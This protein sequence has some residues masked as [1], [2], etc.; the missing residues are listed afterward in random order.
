MDFDKG[1]LVFAGL[2]PSMEDIPDDDFDDDMGS[3]SN[4]DGMTGEK[5]LIIKNYLMT[6][7]GAQ[8][9]SSQKIENLTHNFYPTQICEITFSEKEASNGTPA[10]TLFLSFVSGVFSTKNFM[11]ALRVENNKWKKHI[12]IKDHHKDD[13]TA[14]V[15]KKNVLITLGRDLSMSINVFN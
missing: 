1:T 6:G 12:S 8:F 9:I 11:V 7:K 4:E 2:S 3:S 14:M 13:Q 5:A 15:L 10:K